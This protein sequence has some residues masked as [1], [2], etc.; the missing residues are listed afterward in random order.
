MLRHLTLKEGL[1]MYKVYDGAGNMSRAKRRSVTFIFLMNR[2]PQ[3][4]Y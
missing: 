3:D 2:G 1:G 4:Q